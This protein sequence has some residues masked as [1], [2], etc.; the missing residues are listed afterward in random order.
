MTDNSSALA[1]L[2]KGNFTPKDQRLHE[3]ISRKLARTMMSHNSALYSQYVKGCQNNIADSL[4]RD[5]HIPNS[6]LTFLHK[7]L[8]PTQAGANYHILN[9]L[10]DEITSWIASLKDDSTR[11]VA[12]PPT[13]SKSKLGDLINGE[14]SWDTVTSRVNTWRDLVTKRKCSQ[15]LCV[16]IYSALQRN[17]YKPQTK[18]QTRRI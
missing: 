17:H 15:E 4:S 1:W 14:N 12:F 2:H 16:E 11:T 6:K 8:Y 5:F 10:L 7:S 3:S 9:Q 18:L 13:H